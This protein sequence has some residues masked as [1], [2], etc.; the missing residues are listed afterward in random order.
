[1]EEDLIRLKAELILGGSVRIP[2]DWKIPVRI[3]RSTAGPGA[4]SRAIVLRF[5]DLRVKKSISTDEGEF[6]LVPY[7]GGIR[8]EKDGR[9]LIDEVEIEPVIYHSPGQAFFNLDQSCEFHCLFCNSPLLGV[10]VTKGLTPEKIADMVAEASE[11]EDF[12][13][14]ALTSGVVGGVEATVERMARTVELI[15]ERVPWAPF[16]VEPYVNDPEQIYRL[17]DAGA[18]E[19]KIN[20]E[21]ADS[22]IFSIVCPDLDYNNL[23]EMIEIAVEVFGR[24]KVSSNIIVGLGESDEAIIAEVE[25]LAE[26]GCVAGLRPLKV[27]ELNRLALEEALGSLRQPSPERLIRLGEEQ[28]R[29]LDEHGLD[30]RTFSTMCFECRCCDLVPFRDF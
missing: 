23:H 12:V 4:G 9:T 30:T 7:E 24:G 27:N 5:N 26:M 20:V 14:I 22:V 2:K 16:G 19:I 25:H 11:R 10:E 15:K 28:K 13:S 6:D 21:S 8:L 18:D 3:S 17:R 1:M 29:I